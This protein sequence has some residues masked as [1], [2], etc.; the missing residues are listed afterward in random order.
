M[1]AFNDGVKDEL[2]RYYP[3]EDFTA[4]EFNDFTYIPKSR[5]IDGA[6]AFILAPLGKSPDGSPWNS[7][8]RPGLKHDGAYMRDYVRKVNEAG[9]V[10]TIDI[11]LY[12]DGRFDLEQLDALKKI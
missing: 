10:V 7:W 11:A 1:V 3:D 4:G 12:R 8:C 6:Q 5:F 9:G 2:V